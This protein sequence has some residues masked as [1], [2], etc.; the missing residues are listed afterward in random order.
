MLQGHV[1]SVERQREK[2]PNKVGETEKNVLR[3][4]DK[5]LKN[6]LVLK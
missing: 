3:Q 1:G 5:I 4:M 2:T 6:N